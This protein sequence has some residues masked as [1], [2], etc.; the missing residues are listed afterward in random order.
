[1]ASGHTPLRS[2]PY[3]LE[4]DTPDVAADMQSLAVALDNAPVVKQGT[5][6]ARPASA[7]AGNRYL[8]QGDPNTSNNGI[9]WYDTGSGWL[10]VVSPISL[11]T[12]LPTTPYDGQV[13]D[14]LA[15]ATNGII[16]R[17]R[18][19]AASAS[20]YK[21]E[22]LGGSSLFSQVMTAQSSSTF[23]TWLNLTTAG[24][25]IT[26]P[27]GL[28]GDFA[29][30]MG[31]TMNAVPPGGSAFMGLAVNATAPG[32]GAQPWPER[33]AQGAGSATAEDMVASSGQLSS[34]AAAA[35]LKAQYYISASTGTV[36]FGARFLEIRP[37]RVG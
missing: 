13:I 23:N 31:C 34:V 9:E 4:T 5:L 10:Q 36:T 17:L 26:L 32:F 16:W 6:A 27:T 18:Y 28:G 15:D 30:R 2:Y 3:P 11:V 21:W 29:W 35:V 7:V 12:S 25:Q 14:F 19:R 33:S 20:S 8:V 22:F 37:I 24:P 1:M